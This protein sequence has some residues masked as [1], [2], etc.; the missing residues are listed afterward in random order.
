MVQF[1]Q[2]HDCLFWRELALAACSVATS[3]ALFSTAAAAAAAAAVVVVVCGML[4]VHSTLVQ[5]KVCRS[6]RE[7]STDPVL[8]VSP[9]PHPHSQ[10]PF[11]GSTLTGSPVRKAAGCVSNLC[12]TEPSDAKQ[13]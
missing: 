1:G 5:M 2:Q 6:F 12:E 13:E 4:S 9:P 11:C 10:R 3:A 7:E 8:V